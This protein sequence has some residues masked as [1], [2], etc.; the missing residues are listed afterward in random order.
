MFHCNIVVLQQ[1]PMKAALYAQLNEAAQPESIVFSSTSSKQRKLRHR[2]TNSGSPR[3]SCG[4]PRTSSTRN[5]CLVDSETQT[6]NMDIS[7]TDTSPSAHLASR[8][9]HHR[10]SQPQRVVVEEVVAPPAGDVETLN[11]N[12]IQLHYLEQEPG[13][14]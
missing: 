9:F 11:G 14:Y 1:S 2:R 5:S 13:K 3:T 7:E 12:C 6:D 8:Q 4:S 10:I